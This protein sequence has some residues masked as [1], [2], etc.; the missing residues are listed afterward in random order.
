M[1]SPATFGRARRIKAVVQGMAT[2]AGLADAWALELAAE[3][4]NLGYV[5]LPAE[6]VE[7]V[8]RGDP[9]TPHERAL[10]EK[11][12]A[13]THQLLRHIP[14]LDPVWAILEQVSQPPRERALPAKL[15]CAATEYD[16]GTLSGATPEEVVESLR[17]GELHEP[18]VLAALS[19]AIGASTQGLKVSLLPLSKLSPGQV[20]AGDIHGKSGA[21]LMVKGTPITSALL[22]RLRNI[23]EGA[24]VQEPIRIWEHGTP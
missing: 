1:A 6:T 10:V 2:A 24:G 17:R 19:S 3:L 11:V 7:K 18:P 23:A 22:D 4:C 5:S 16:N 20:L 14:R 15:L 12:P 9:L 13:A 8:Y 21:L